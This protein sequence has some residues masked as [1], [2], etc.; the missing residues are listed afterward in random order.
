MRTADRRGNGHRRNPLRLACG[1]GH[2]SGN[3]QSIAVLHVAIPHE[4]QE[5]T[6]PGALLNSRDAPSLV[7]RRVWLESSR[8][9]KST[10]ARF[11]LPLLAPKPL[12]PLGGGQ[13][14][15]SVDQIQGTV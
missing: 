13:V 7:E 8:P 10:L 1:L 2:R 11:L 4:A 6:T 3:N 12:P 14:I 15:E 5:A 9:W